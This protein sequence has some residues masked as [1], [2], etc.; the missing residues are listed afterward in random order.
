MRRR[1][2][3]RIVPLSQCPHPYGPRS[4]DSRRVLVEATQCPGAR[5]GKPGEVGIP[6][7]PCPPIRSALWTT[8]FVSGAKF[9]LPLGFLPPACLPHAR[10]LPAGPNGSTRSSTTA[11]ASWPDATAIGSGYSLAGITIG[12]ASIVGLSTRFCP[13]GSGP[14]LWM[15]RRFGQDRTASPFRQAAFQCP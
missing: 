2:I 6:A 15:G 8:M 11:T 4:R 7:D 13:L 3:P 9:S 5:G 12:R 10:G 1:L 14:S